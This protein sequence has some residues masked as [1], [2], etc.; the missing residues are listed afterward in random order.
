MEDTFGEDAFMEAIMCFKEDG[1]V[2]DALHEPLMQIVDALEQISRLDQDI[3]MTGVFATHLLSALAIL[4]LQI[5]FPN[6]L[7]HLK[8]VFDKMGALYPVQF[9]IHAAAE[10]Q[11]MRALLFEK[12]VEIMIGSSVRF[13]EE[14]GGPEA[15]IVGDEGFSN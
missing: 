11:N 6:F 12:P 14:D 1:R 10:D 15:N 4:F 7:E 5:D 2:D 13:G 8:E 9:S 3:Q